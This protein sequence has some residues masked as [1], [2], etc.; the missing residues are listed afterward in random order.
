MNPLDEMTW[1]QRFY[2]AM[3]ALLAAEMRYEDAERQLR[4]KES[5]RK[6]DLALRPFMALRAAA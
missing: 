6:V 3:Y 2:E 1:E 4:H 5:E